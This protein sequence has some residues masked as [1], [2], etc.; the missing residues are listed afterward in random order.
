M[1]ENIKRFVKNI[2]SIKKDVEEQQQQEGRE[3]TYTKVKPKE[4]YWNAQDEMIDM[5]LPTSYWLRSP[6]AK[7]SKKGTVYIVIPFKKKTRDMQ[8]GLYKEMKAMK[9][10]D[11]LTAESEAGQRL[12]KKYGQNFFDKVK[13]THR[14]SPMQN[15]TKVARIP[16]GNSHSYIS[17]R[18]LSTASRPGTWIISRQALQRALQ[19]KSKGFSKSLKGIGA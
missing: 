1:F 10:G 18:T 5:K 13:E 16:L 8:P 2:F 9:T 12:M 3:K 19:H 14:T 17:F 7:H 6:K 4:D 11:R 15:L